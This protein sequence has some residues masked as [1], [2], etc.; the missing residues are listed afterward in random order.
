MSLG[1]GEE[2]SF[3]LSVEAIDT[4]SREEPRIMRVVSVANPDDTKELNRI[5]MEIA[6]LKPKVSA[7]ERD[8]QP[9]MELTT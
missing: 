3:N 1:L 5:L 7:I 9:E 6:N 8:N 4:T 2:S